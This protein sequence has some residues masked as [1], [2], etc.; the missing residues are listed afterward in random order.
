MGVPVH[1]EGSNTVA[2]RTNWRQSELQAEEAYFYKAHA[3]DIA[4]AELNTDGEPTGRRHYMMC[5]VACK[6]AKLA[7]FEP[8]TPQDESWTHYTQMRIRWNG[9]DWLSTEQAEH[10]GDVYATLE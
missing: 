8:C 7:I 5:N 4:I 2:Y 6:G 3:T 9:M 10:A 1:T